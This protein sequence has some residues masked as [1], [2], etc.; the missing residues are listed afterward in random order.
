MRLNGKRALLSLAALGMAW[1]QP[2]APIGMTRGALMTWSGTARLGEF[3]F[4]NADNI[5]YRC[6]YDDKTYFERD[7]ERIFIGGTHQGD[8]LEVLSDRR[9]GSAQCY[10]RI[11][12]V[13]DAATVRAAAA[14]PKT[15]VGPTE[16]FALR[17]DLTFA[18]VVIRINAESLLLRTRAGARKTILLRADTR[19]LGG[20][21]PLDRNA[22]QLNTPVFIRAGRNL[23]DEVEAF[24]IVW[25][26][27]LEPVR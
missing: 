26:D 9:D 2:G 3:L 12:H 27:I 11:V 5:V 4:R 19:Y 14:R 8:R 10:A 23:E 25:G 15:R 17:G 20:G 24:Q 18:G 16:V 6:S 13:L 21:E 1:A 22:L 7:R